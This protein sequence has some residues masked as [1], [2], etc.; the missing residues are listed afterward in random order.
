M[1]EKEGMGPKRSKKEEQKKT[2]GVCDCNQCLKMFK[3]LKVGFTLKGK[4]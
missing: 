3:L 4:K 2:M 1:W